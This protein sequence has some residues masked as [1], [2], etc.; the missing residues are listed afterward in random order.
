MNI[1]PSYEDLTK[2]VSELEIEI[3]NLKVRFD[4]PTGI[5]HAVNGV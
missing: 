2:R 5:V 3:K 4:T 1:K